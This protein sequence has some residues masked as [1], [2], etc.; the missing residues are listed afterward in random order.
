MAD[1]D[2]LTDL[3]TAPIFEDAVF[4]SEALQHPECQTEEDLDAQLAALAQTAGIEDPYRFLSPTTQAF[5]QEESSTTIDSDPRSSTSLYSRETHSPALTS[6]TSKDFPQ[7]DTSPAQRTPQLS[8]RSSLAYED[9]YDTMMKRF[10]INARDRPSS[11]ASDVVSADS[12]SS[13]V[14]C[15]RK[16]KRGGS[17]FFS[18]FRS[19]SYSSG[20]SYRHHTK[21]SR[22]RLDSGHS[23]PKYDVQIHVEDLS[24]T[25]RTS[26]D[27]CDKARSKALH[28]ILTMNDAGSA[29]SS[30]AS[31]PLIKAAPTPRYSSDSPSSLELPHPSD[32]PTPTTESLEQPA[33]PNHRAFSDDDYLTLRSK[34][35]HQFRRITLFEAHQHKAL[36]AHHTATLARLTSQFHES[37]SSR[38]AQ[39][40]TTLDTLEEAHLLAEH[41]LRQSQAQESQN[42]ATALKHMTAYCTGKLTLPGEQHH[43]TVTDEDRAKLARQKHLQEKL[44]AKH[45]SAINVLRAR[46]ERGIKTKMEQQEAELQGLEREFE[47]KKK[48]LETGYERD[49]A[50]LRALN[51]SRR[52][53]VGAQWDLRYEIW[54]IEWERK[55]GEKID[56]RVPQEA[57]PEQKMDDATDIE[58]T[59]A[60]AVYLQLQAL[61]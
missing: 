41:D 4:L 45:E 39:H 37:Q 1:P 20:S 44:P 35:K 59:S 27:S 10:R 3:T 28:A 52:R 7:R 40:L 43:H 26:F 61:V 34:Q 47:G 2:L 29:M 49:L 31:S 55:E 6:R 48:E 54:R 12:G 53:K 33:D 18:I 56:G 23:S 58:A 32:Y 57:W 42:V 30:T 14:S 51:V 9:C 25:P 15:S 5:A 24:E 8:G 38:S 17:G 21:L 36:S 16:P 46:Q 11:F 13:S 19:S 22:A 60:L 50:R